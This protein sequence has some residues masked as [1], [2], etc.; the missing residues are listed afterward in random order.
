MERE[1]VK[2]WHPTSASLFA[3]LKNLEPAKITA[4]RLDQNLHTLQPRIVHWAL[5]SFW[6]DVESWPTQQSKQLALEALDDLYAPF[7]P[8]VQF[9][10]ELDARHVHQFAKEGKKSAQ[11][12][13]G[14][15]YQEVDKLPQ[16]AWENLINVLREPSPALQSTMLG[17][18]K[19][20]PIAKIADDIP[21]PEQIRPIDDLGL[22]ATPDPKKVIFG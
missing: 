9:Y 1:R 7:L 8:C 12:P 17:L 3:Y 14:W 15:A 10:F 21:W 22:F 4:V 16:R 5:E 20:I 18:V 13:D 19:R 11:G 2:A 6:E